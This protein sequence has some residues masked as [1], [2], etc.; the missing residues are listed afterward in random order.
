MTEMMDEVTGDALGMTP[1]VA[2]S[3]LAQSASP[4]GDAVANDVIRH[5]NHD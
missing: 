4:P 5:L 1:T 3:V 2:P